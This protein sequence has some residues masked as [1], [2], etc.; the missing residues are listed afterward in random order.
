MYREMK[1]NIANS[2]AASS[3][4]TTYEPVRVRE[5][6]TS[7]GTSGAF[8]RRSMTMNEVSRTR[9]TAISAIVSV[10]PQPALLAFTSE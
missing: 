6:K 3:T 9:L 4:P 2:E 1:K 8:E 10:E 5:E 7:N